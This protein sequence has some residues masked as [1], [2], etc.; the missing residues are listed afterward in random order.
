[1]IL[2]VLVVVL[3][4]CVLAPTLYRRF[5]EKG[6]VGSI[7]HFHRQLT[8]L[9]HAGPK[10]VNPAYRLHSAVPGGAVDDA[11][12]DVT[13]MYRAKLVLLRPT[14]DEGSADIDDTAGTHYERVGVL[15]PPEPVT[16]YDHTQAELAAYRRQEA[17]R[18][19]SNIV[20]VLIGLTISTLIIGFVPS[21]RLA[22]IFTAITGLMLGAL[23]AL[24]AYAR[25]IERGSVRHAGAP[26]F[27]LHN[28]IDD[29]VEDDESHLGAATAGYPGAWDDDADFSHQA[30]ASG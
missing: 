28:Y 25:E 15:D 16:S 3:W 17:R 22:W 7:D 2:L 21:L 5:S 12:P 23:I 18:R 27:A 9:E 13:P 11:Q 26:S 20:L 4:I 29:G 24:I 6:G 30:A 14:D 19:T 1:M 10:L 8:T